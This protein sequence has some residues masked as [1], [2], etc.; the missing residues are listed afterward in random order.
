MELGSL[1]G[2]GLVSA[3]RLGS[4]LWL[5]PRLEL[6]LLVPLA[7]GFSAGIR[8]GAAFPLLRRTFVVNGDNPIYHPEIPSARFNAGIELSL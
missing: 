7:L 5:A 4:S 3:P 1:R 6:G 2:E 8:G